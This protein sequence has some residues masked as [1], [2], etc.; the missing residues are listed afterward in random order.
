M[1]ARGAGARGSRRAP[2]RAPPPRRSARRR[3]S[4]PPG[5]RPLSRRPNPFRRLPSSP[6]RACRA[7]RTSRTS[8]RW[9]TPRSRTC[10]GPSGRLSALCVFPCTSVFYGTFVWAHGAL[11]SQK[12][13]FLARAAGRSSPRFG[14]RRASSARGRLLARGGVPHPSATFRSCWNV[15][16][17]RCV[18]PLWEVSWP[19]GK[20]LWITTSA[21]ASV[22]GSGSVRPLTPDLVP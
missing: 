9:G 10:P 14:Q 5:A 12:R 21:C 19:A 20:A 4:R 11:N 18:H 17:N 15:A 2:P 6:R 3:R 1:C 7:I 16:L 8:R 13:W 22:R